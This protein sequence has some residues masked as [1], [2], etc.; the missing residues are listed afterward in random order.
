MNIKKIVLIAVILMIAISSL[1]MVSA[2]WF[3][4]LNPGKTTVNGIEFNVTGF[5]EFTSDA[6][7]GQG[8]LKKV[9]IGSEGAH[10]EIKS[11]EDE[12]GN[13]LVICVYDNPNKNLTLDKIQ[14]NGVSSNVKI[15]NATNGGKDG[16]YL[17]IPS[18]AHHSASEFAYIEDGKLVVLHIEQSKSSKNIYE[19]DIIGHK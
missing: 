15:K 14:F 7:L 10:S 3:D 1:S 6:G 13:S 19:S 9:I 17:S 18:D 11:F 12:N 4:F 16:L 8:V 5:K 2:G